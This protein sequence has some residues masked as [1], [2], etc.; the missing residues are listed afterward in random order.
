MSGPLHG[1]YQALAVAFPGRG[2]GIA[3][4][5]GYSG[6]STTIW[7][8]FERT[9]DGGRHWTAG[10]PARGQH[11]PGAQAGLAFVSARQ[12]WAYG[13]DLFFTRDGGATWRA[14]PAPFLLTG[15]V[16][17]A[18]T[19]TWVVGYACPRADC[20]ATVYTTTGVGGALRRLSVQPTGTGNVIVMRRPS[21][22]MAWLLLALP[23][24][25]LRLATTSDAGRSW[26]TRALPCPARD[27]VGLQLSAPG[28][29]SLWL[30]CQGTPGAGSV[31]GVVYRTA[32]GGRTWRR[33]GAE[34]AL[35]VYA[36]SGRAA[37]AVASN[38][39]NSLVM[40]TTDG[41]RTWH[42]VLSRPDTYVE[43][44]VAQGPDAAQVIAPVFRANGL[45]FV[46]YRTS[47]AGKT[48]Q[49]AAL[50]LRRTQRHRK[51]DPVLAPVAGM[52]ISDPGIRP[53]PGSGLC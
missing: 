24:G 44:F 48:W 28:P 32:D 17:V 12:G 13:P 4:I 38:A 46:A 51:T 20:P 14:E 42:T 43:A 9:S 3:A 27:R 7:S 6:Q 23:H 1:K 15:P 30:V 22:T 49:R 11:Q 10:R 36:V 52:T 18:G 26:A 16:A 35:S 8:W 5:A 21:R 31:P 29:G 47:D 37:W 40:R 39:S 25:R 45:S 53:R 2:T 41:G 33:M 50:R 19:S 34:N